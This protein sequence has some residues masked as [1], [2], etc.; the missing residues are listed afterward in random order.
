MN[1]AEAYGPICHGGSRWRSASGTD[2]DV[3]GLARQSLNSDHVGG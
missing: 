2:R 1:I 3:D